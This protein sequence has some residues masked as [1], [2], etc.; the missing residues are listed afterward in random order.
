M[1]SAYNQRRAQCEAAAQQLGLAALRDISWA[2]FQQRAGELDET[3]RRRARH[4]VGENLRTLQAAAAMRRNDAREL[5]RLMN[6]SHASLRD[7]FEVSSPALDAIVAAARAHPACLG[8]RMTGAG[9]G[10]CA[11]ALVEA[12]RAAEFTSALAH[13]YAQRTNLSPTVTLCHASDGV[14]AQKLL[15]N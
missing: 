2:E 10:G 12:E 5:G 3:S 4:V 9:F 15:P 8:A 13:D 14:K 7:D 11:V 1:N 6:A